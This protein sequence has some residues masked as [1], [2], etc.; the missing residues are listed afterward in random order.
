M[1]IDFHTLFKCIIGIVVV[2]VAL[3]LVQMWFSPFQWFT[4]WKILAT[5]GLLGGLVSFFIAVKQ[6]IT[7]EKKLRDDKYLE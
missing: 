7:E 4:F 6:D 5:L 1:K 3:I 2:G